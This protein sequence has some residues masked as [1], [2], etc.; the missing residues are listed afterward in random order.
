MIPNKNINVMTTKIG[1]ITILVLFHDSTSPGG[2]V[3]YLRKLK[4]MEF[5]YT[6]F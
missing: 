3:I 1:L 6:N 2:I 4:G 5:I